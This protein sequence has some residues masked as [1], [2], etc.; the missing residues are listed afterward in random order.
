LATVQLQSD[1]DNLAMPSED[2]CELEAKLDL[3]YQSVDDEKIP[4]N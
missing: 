4:L 1:G 3:K 2:D